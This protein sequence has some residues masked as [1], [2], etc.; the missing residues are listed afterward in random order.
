MTR[1]VPGTHDLGLLART[2]DALL[3]VNGESVRIPVFDKLA[4]DRRS[5]PACRVEKGGADIVLLEGWCIGARPQNES[6][7]VEPINDLEALE[8]EDRRWRTYVNEQLATTYRALFDR[9]ALRVMLKAPSFDV[10][11]RWRREQE[12]ALEVADQR[13]GMDMGAIKRFVSHYERLTR[14]LDQDEPA[15]LVVELDRHRVPK[16]WRIVS[17]MGVNS[18]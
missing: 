1:G 16:S 12:Q 17:G 3:H 14:W 15:D 11:H 5:N 9:L 2:L 10:I 13:G 18:P 4:D 6:D 7:L 8:D